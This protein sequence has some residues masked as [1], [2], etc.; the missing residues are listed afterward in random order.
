M[1]SY[2]TYYGWSVIAPAVVFCLLWLVFLLLVL[3]I[4]P[5]CDKPPRIFVEMLQLSLPDVEDD[6][7][8]IVKIDGSDIKKTFYIL[9]L[10]MIPISIATIYFVFWVV[11]LVEEEVT[12]ACV[13]NFD[14]FP[15]LGDT[16][17]QSLPVENCSFY[18]N[19]SMIADLL[20]ATAEV[21]MNET[22]VAETS[23]EV[24]YECY[25]FV[26]RYAE[27]LGAAGGVL[28][29]TAAFSKVYFG[30][31]VAI[32]KYF[33]EEKYAYLGI[34]I[35]GGIACVLWLLFVLFNTVFSDIRKSV[36]QTHSDYIEFSLYTL[37]FA[38]VI[39]GGIIIGVGIILE[40]G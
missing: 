38:A 33:D 35:V 40:D 36:F 7:G 21:V 18:S 32:V 26:Y 27:G 2:D 11:W 23:G 14:C 28:F 20:N 25:R 31:I 22:E 37:N 5:F 30:L 6:K 9:T 1:A 16:M 8:K 4:Y 15:F 3:I 12:G 34:I 39:A 17:L 24:T 19:T 10:V 13:P 29:F